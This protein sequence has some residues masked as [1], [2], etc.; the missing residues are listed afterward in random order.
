MGARLLA[1]TILTSHDRAS[2]EQL[3]LSGAPEDHV[4]R[5]ALL[6][7]E[8]GVDGVVAS[9]QEAALVRQ[10]CGRDLVIVTPG[11]RPPGA[12]A[13]DQAR[14][15]TP[16]AAIAA[17]ADYLVV[18]RPITEAADPALAVASLTQDLA[19]V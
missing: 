17:G 15:A 1:V 6:A 11:I 2:L 7:R 9:P 8:A 18:G 19:A 12:P 3:G 4:R 5:L 10:A 14:T 13:R 16:A